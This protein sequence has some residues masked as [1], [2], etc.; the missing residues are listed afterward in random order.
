MSPLALKGATFKGSEE[1]HVL[2]TAGST[3]EGVDHQ[4]LC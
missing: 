4:F 3:F 2:R 1:A